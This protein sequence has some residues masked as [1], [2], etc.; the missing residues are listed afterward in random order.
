[1]SKRHDINKWLQPPHGACQFPGRG[2]DEEETQQSVG[3]FVRNN[4]FTHAIILNTET[5]EHYELPDNGVVMVFLTKK[6]AY[7]MRDALLNPD[8][9]PEEFES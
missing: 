3:V 9:F 8:E 7:A 6:G 2:E 5:K 1:V 4:E